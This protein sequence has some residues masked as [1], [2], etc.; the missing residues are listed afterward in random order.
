MVALSAL[1]LPILVSGVAVF[2]VSAIVWMA[3]PHHKTDFS[4]PDDQDALMEAVRASTTGPGMYYFP[5]AGPEGERSDAYRARVHTGPVGILRVRD[6]KSVLDMRSAIMKSLVLHL[7]AALFVGYL[8]SATLPQGTD[9][10]KVFQVTATAA[11]MA[12]GVHRLPGMHL[13]RPPRARRLQARSRRTGLRAPD[14]SRLRRNVAR[15]SGPADPN[16]TET[17]RST[18]R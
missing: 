3:M 4:P 12:H 6:P 8:G 17:Q 7:A 11:F 5:W 9:F 2:I 16:P 14:R 10:P 1:W 18:P 13:V 15:L